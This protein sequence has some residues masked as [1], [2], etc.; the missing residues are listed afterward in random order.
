MERT[1]AGLPPDPIGG[2]FELPGDSD[3]VPQRDCGTQQ[4]INYAARRGTS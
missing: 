3:L 2:F 4:G 1:I